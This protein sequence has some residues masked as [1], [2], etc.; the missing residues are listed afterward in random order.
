MFEDW[1]LTALI[2]T[3]LVGALVMLFIPNRQVNAIRTWALLVSAFALVISLL[4][5]L[6]FDNEVKGFQFV[7]AFDWIGFFGIQYK[8]GVDG[9][10]LVLVLL[11]TLLTLISILA[12]FGP[13]KARVKEYMIAFLVLEVGMLVS[14]AAPTAS[15]P[16]S[17]SSSTR[18]SARC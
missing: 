11:T 13:I 7:Q 16:R 12:S 1:I 6:A 18:W 17:S 2:F 9:I 8:V 3:P 4:L 5:A 14:G 15:T 10:S